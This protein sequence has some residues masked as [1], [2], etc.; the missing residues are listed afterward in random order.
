MY[1][2]F[3]VSVS[4]CRSQLKKNM[5]GF[6]LNDIESYATCKRCHQLWQLAHWSIGWPRLLYGFVM[7]ADLYWTQRCACLAVKHLTQFPKNPKWFFSSIFHFIVSSAQ[8]DSM[9][10]D[11]E[12]HTAYQENAF[13]AWWR[14][15]KASRK[16]AY[17]ISPRMFE[18]FKGSITANLN[19]TQTWARHQWKRHTKKMCML[20]D[21]CRTK[22]HILS[23]NSPNRRSFSHGFIYRL[24]IRW[25]VSSASHVLASP[26]FAAQTVSMQF[27]LQLQRMNVFVSQIISFSVIPGGQCELFDESNVTVKV[28][29]LLKVAKAN[30]FRLFQIV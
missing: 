18:Q 4:F 16:E 17:L 19:R 23:T 7:P 27:H 15:K 22:W 29:Q 1:A 13:D 14:W 3:C 25:Q 30:V 2:I 28:T 24:L 21:R 6:G 10:G 26:P 8:S 20:C 9:A 5:C 11:T 12:T